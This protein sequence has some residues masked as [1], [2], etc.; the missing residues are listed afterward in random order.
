MAFIMTV[1]NFKRCMNIL[2]IENMIAKIKNWKPNYKAIARHLL[3]WMH[4]NAITRIRKNQLKF[5]A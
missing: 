3:K 2:G 1:Y 5:A 4:I